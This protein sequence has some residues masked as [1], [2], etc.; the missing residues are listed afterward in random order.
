MSEKPALYVVEKKEVVI[1]VVLFVLVTVLAFTMGVRYGESVGK[2]AALSQA[3]AEGEVGA[4]HA[5]HTGG[6]LGSSAGDHG[7][8]DSH[9]A[10]GHAKDAGHGKEAGG[11]GEK[12]EAPKAAAKSSPEVSEAPG[13]EAADKNSDE[14][15][16]N[17][18]KESGVEPPGGKAPNDAKLP[19]E[20]KRA[21]SGS[22]VIQVGSHPTKGEA[23]SQLRMLASKKIDAEILAPFKDRQGEWH[24]VV[25]GSYKTKRDAEKEAGQLKAKGA[26]LSYFVWRLP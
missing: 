24:R 23:E 18:L 13:R 19:S 22:Y 10:S 17:A 15:L 11:H 25:I 9:G 8:E 6:T 7:E 21:K 12:A 1:L 3:H 2:K 4:E 14:F 5:E 26:I 20:V 16:L